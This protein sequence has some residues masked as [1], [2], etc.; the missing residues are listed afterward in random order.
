M[1]PSITEISQAALC[2]GRW[3]FQCST[4]HTSMATTTDR[5]C[6]CTIGLH[7]WTWF[8]VY[9]S[10]F[11]DH[12]VVAKEAPL[13]GLFAWPVFERGACA[14]ARCLYSVSRLRLRCVWWP[15]ST[16]AQSQSQRRLCLALSPPLPACRQLLCFNRGCLRKREKGPRIQR[17]SQRFACLLSFEFW[18]R[19]C[20]GHGG[21]QLWTVLGYLL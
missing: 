12:V 2:D 6:P 21:F 19:L 10:L 18:L 3:Q 11:Q 7:A 8:I 9:I 17:D 14:H 5:A 1:A 20:S 13:S 15:S 4:A 16:H